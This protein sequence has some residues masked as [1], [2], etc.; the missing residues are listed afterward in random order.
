MVWRVL[1]KDKKQKPLAF[2]EVFDAAG[3][4][5]VAGPRR[6]VLGNRRRKAGWKPTKCIP[7]SEWDQVD[8]GVSAVPTP[9]KTSTDHPVSS[10]LYR[11]SRPPRDVAARRDSRGEQ[12][13]NTPAVTA[14]ATSSTR[15]SPG[16][17]PSN[18]SGPSRSDS[19]ESSSEDE[20][21]VE[22]GPD[23]KVVRKA[24]D[25]ARSCSIRRGGNKTLL[26]QATAIPGRGRDARTSRRESNMLALYAATKMSHSASRLAGARD[27]LLGSAAQGAAPNSRLLASRDSIPKIQE[28]IEE[29]DAEDEE[30]EKKDGKKGLQSPAPKSAGWSNF[31]LLE[32]SKEF[33][34]PKN[35]ISYARRL[36]D[37]YDASGDGVL[38][39]E[40]FQLLIRGLLKEQYPKV[41]DVPKELFEGIDTSQDGELD[42]HEFLQWF[43]TNSFSEKVLLDPSQQRIRGLSRK[44]KVAIDFVEDTQHAFNRF[45][46]DQSGEID[47]T[48]FKQLLNVLLKVPSHVDLP[49]NRVRSFWKEIDAD[50]SGFV[51]FE[52]FFAWYRRY[53]E[54]GKNSFRSPIEQFYASVRW[55]P[56][57]RTAQKFAS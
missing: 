45:D 36:F 7:V 19:D 33:N 44:Y 15:D 56:G 6:H 10:G 51:D 47:E 28:D 20:F 2:S 1:G 49:D 17:Q 35:T 26:A 31:D 30:S 5:S 53:F 43:T 21:N 12:P 11:G 52:E 57:S 18:E 48:E 55:V 4:Q 29:G 22:R 34:L 32:V 50:N 37:R 16:S 40:E 8:C 42:F 39:P 41:K 24:C 46:V 54:G 14:N 38:D 9:C 23:G 13:S 25:L 27:S 3:P